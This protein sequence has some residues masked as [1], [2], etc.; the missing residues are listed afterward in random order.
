LGVIT[1]LPT[2][3]ALKSP[4][5]WVQIL[6]FSDTG[7]TDSAVL[8]VVPVVALDDASVV[9][10]VPVPSGAGAVVTVAEVAVVPLSAVVEAVVV[11]VA[12]LQPTNATSA[13]TRTISARTRPT[14]LVFFFILS[15]PSPYS[16]ESSK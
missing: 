2:R 3:K 1:L 4:W 14:L 5:H 6:K 11:L 12:D 13:V 8:P 16:R 9:A 10:V 7:E 15:P